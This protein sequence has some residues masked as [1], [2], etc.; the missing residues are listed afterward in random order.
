[1]RKQETPSDPQKQEEPDS[2]PQPSEEPAPIDVTSFGRKLAEIIAKVVQ[3][4]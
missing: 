3:A 2:A 4:S 1:M